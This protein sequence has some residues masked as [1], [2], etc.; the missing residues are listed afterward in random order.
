M[1][2]GATGDTLGRIR[3]SEDNGEHGHRWDGL[4]ARIQRLA[5]WPVVRSTVTGFFAV[6]D[7][8]DI[9]TYLGRVLG[10]RSEPKKKPVPRVMFAR[11]T[12]TTPIEEKQPTFQRV[13]RLR[14]RSREVMGVSL[15]RLGRSLADPQPGNHLEITLAVVEPQI[16]QQARPL[17]DH[18]QQP[19]AAGMV[20]GMTLEVLG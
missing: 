11:V 13:D 5:T 15:R 2:R 3:G 1:P 17:R 6:K 8:V 4:L 10:G 18:H 14:R 12:G 16:L 7:A 9:H 20:L 19:A